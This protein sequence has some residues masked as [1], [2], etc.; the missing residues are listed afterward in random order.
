M[1]SEIK[2]DATPLILL[3][4]PLTLNRLTRRCSFFNAYVRLSPNEYEVLEYL[5][6]HEGVVC[7]WLETSKRREHQLRRCQP[8]GRSSA[9]G[10]RLYLYEQHDKQ[11]LRQT[12]FRYDNELE[13]DGC[14]A[15]YEGPHR[16]R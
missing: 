9:W 6:I 7:S 11:N 5:L 14:D 1:N 15:V 8:Q 4:G 13:A 12:G 16:V 3:H 2:E 10:N